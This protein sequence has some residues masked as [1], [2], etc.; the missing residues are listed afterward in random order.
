V[1][2]RVEGLDGQGRGHVVGHGGGGQRAVRCDLRHVRGSRNGAEC[3]R[4]GG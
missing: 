1:L 2:G 4:R 3:G